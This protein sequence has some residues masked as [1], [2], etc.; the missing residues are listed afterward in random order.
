M[1]VMRDRDSGQQEETFLELFFDLVFVFAVTQLSRQ[2]FTHQDW[3]GAGR[4]AFMLLVVWWAWI[5]TTWMTNWFNPQAVAVRLTLLTGML[6]SMAMAVAIP[7]AFSTEAP[8]FAGGYVGL[9]LLRNVFI[10]AAT[11]PVSPLHVAFRRILAW[12][13][14]VGAIW[15]AGALV[16][17]QARV[18]VWLAALALDYAGPF[19]G[20]WTP[21]L[22]RTAVTDWEIEHAHFAGRFQTFIMIALGEEIVLTVSAASSLHLDG[23][24]AVAAVAAFVLGAALWWLYFDEVADKATGDFARA[25][26]DRGRLGRDAYTYLHLPIVAG[27]IVAA[28]GADITIH[29]PDAVPDTAQAIVLAAGPALYLLGHIGF[30][31]RMIGSVSRVRV[32]ATALI[33]VAA[34][35]LAH[36]ARLWTGIATALILVALAGDETANRLRSQRSHKPASSG[37]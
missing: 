21:G 12:S 30:R 16:G 3:A 14:W 29:H 26:D 20:Y 6:A 18:F 11:K 33:V 19:A 27:I 17:Q 10:V 23:T 35:A 13:C 25:D 15:I 1:A 9:Q 7:H 2:L 5:Y 34:V 32:G 31:L 8:L 24:R 4:T 37:V 36:T 28:V 22:G